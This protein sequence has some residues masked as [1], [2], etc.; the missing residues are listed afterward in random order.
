MPTGLLDR[1]LPWDYVSSKKPEEADFFVQTVGTNAGKPMTEPS[2]NSVGI[3]V[4]P[5]VLIPEFAYY[6]FEHA[7]NLGK[8]KQL[9]KG[10]AQQY[11]RQGDI[12][13]GV[14]SIFDFTP[15][16]GKMSGAVGSLLDP[17]VTGL[18]E[19]I[20]RD[21][22]GRPIITE[23]VERDRN[24][25]RW[26][27]HSV[28][29]DRDDA[30]Q[31]FY[32]GTPHFIGTSFDPELAGS[33]DHGYYG[34]GHY[35]TKNPGLA[36]M[37]A[38]KVGEHLIPVEKLDEY[39]YVEKP[40]DIAPEVLAF[41]LRSEKPLKLDFN[42]RNPKHQKI[43]QEI[44]LGDLWQLKSTLADSLTFI[45]HNW[46]GS[47]E[48]AREFL[49]NTGPSTSLEG[50]LEFMDMYVDPGGFDFTDLT[51]QAGFDSIDVGEGREVIMFDPKDIKNIHN[52]GTYEE[53]D[54]FMGNL[55]TQKKGLLQ[56]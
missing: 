25:R 30:P 16:V 29:Q 49:R 46:E 23:P 27:G 5:E 43:H 36:N 31:K 37:Y 45:P 50:L 35:F 17:E 6:M 22:Q 56:V 33:R 19:P 1:M 42:K 21:E 18:D 2:A 32:H 7:N 48:E 3:K 20:Y 34:R 53:T 51:R 41:N 54:D 24:F 40:T 8:F 4:N 52:R 39:P 12:D 44:S 38:D 55:G 47:Q 9:Q 15:V 28:Y 26:F 14:S 10:T 13:E 11:L